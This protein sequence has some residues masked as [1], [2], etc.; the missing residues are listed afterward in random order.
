[1][2]DVL[3][4]IVEEL[5]KLGS[6]DEAIALAIDLEEK[7]RA[8]YLDKASE[9]KNP[10]AVNIYNFLAGEEKKHLEYLIKYRDSR[11]VPEMEH[12]VPEFKESLMEEFSDE[13]MQEIGILLGALRFEH[14][15]EFFY[16]E[17][18]K[19]AEDENQRKFFEDVA[20]AERIHYSIIDDLLGAASGFRMQT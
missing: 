3:Q 20:A 11:E 19:R 4:E 2:K 15:S 17:M 18:A 1:M 5:D 10:G 16:M 12:H 13:E 8:Y 14:K 9:M 7:G 6:M